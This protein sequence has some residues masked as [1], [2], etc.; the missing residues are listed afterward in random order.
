MKNIDELREKFFDKLLRKPGTYR[1]AR[2][3]LERSNL[4]DEII[5]ALMNEAEEAGLIDDEGFAKLFIDG[6]LQWGNLKIA[7]ELS[8]RGVS[9]E[10]IA[11]A[12]DEAEDESERA[13]EIAES[14]RK[15][16]LED[17]KINSRLMSRG[18]SNR[19]IRS[20]MKQS[21]S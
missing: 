20:A 15:S 3:I 17:R 12:L 6:H 4:P 11:N 13:I 7:Y 2:E 5:D 9:R 8:A 10:D 19:A 18:F 14:W 16:G 21:N 1:Q